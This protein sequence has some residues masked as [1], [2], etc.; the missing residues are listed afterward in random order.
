MSF[1]FNSGYGAVT[2]NDCNKIIDQGLGLAEYKELW[3]GDRDVCM[4]C[5]LKRNGSVAELDKASAPK[6]E[7][8]NTPASSSLAASAKKKEKRK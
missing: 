5:R 2:C 3:G 7:G 1:R 4:L 8:G 6:A